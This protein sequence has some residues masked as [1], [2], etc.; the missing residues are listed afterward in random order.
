MRRGTG[1]SGGAGTATRRT[2]V[3]GAS[4]SPAPTSRPT[5]TTRRDFDAAPMPSAA[6]DG[7]QEDRSPPGRSQERRLRL[8]EHRARAARRVDRDEQPVA[9]EPVDGAAE[10]GETP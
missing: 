6:R 3:P 7:G 8:G 5:T 10:R 1:V 4:T 9:G 2:T